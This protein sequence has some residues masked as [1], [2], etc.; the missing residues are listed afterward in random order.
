MRSHAHDTYPPINTLKPVVD[1][2][3]IVDGPV[4]RFGFPWPKMPFPT[5]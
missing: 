1:D 2:L 3:W 5:R 4:I